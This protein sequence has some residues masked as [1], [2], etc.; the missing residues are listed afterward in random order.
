[1][2]GVKSKKMGILNSLMILISTIGKEFLCLISREHK[3]N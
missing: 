1:M 2:E 3:R